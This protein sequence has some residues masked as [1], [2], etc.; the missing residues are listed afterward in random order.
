MAEKKAPQLTALRKEHGAKVLGETTV[1]QC[2]GGMRGITC[3]VSETSLLDPMEGI[4]Y[5]GRTLQECMDQLPK[6]PGSKIGLP[7]A[8]KELPMRA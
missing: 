1:G 8:R 7:E 6:A 5:R 2:I 3:L 4:R